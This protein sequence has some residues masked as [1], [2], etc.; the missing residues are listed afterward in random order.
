MNLDELTEAVRQRLQEEKP[1]VLLLGETPVNLRK[2]NY[3]NQKPYD[4]VV[5]GTLSPGQ[6]LQMPTDPVC[7]ALL[8]GMPVYLCPQHYGKGATAPELRRALQ[9][10][11]QRLRRFGALPLEDENRFIS[12][13][14]ARQMVRAGERPPPGSRLTPLARDILEGKEV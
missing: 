12:A 14:Q 3:V 7:M 5:I 9:A 13:Q 1:R 8:E 2:Y 4:A 11:Q 10:A 6:L